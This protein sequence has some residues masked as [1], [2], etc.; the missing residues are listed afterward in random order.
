MT[1]PCERACLGHC[2]QR[3]A[4][5]TG[6]LRH[7]IRK[8][9]TPPGAHSDGCFVP[10]LSVRQPQGSQKPGGVENRRSGFSLPVAMWP[11][12]RIAASVR[13]GMAL[14]PVPAHRTEQARFTHPALGESVTRSPTESWRFAD[15]SRTSPNYRCRTASEYRLVAG[16]VVCAWHTATGAAAAS[17]SVHSS[18]GFA[19]WSQDRNSCPP[20]DFRLSVLTTVSS[21]SRVCA[22]SSL[23]ADRL[24][25]ALHPFLRRSRS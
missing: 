8:K 4:F 14:F 12:F 2:V 15:V 24:T 3:P 20:N 19:D 6:S 1:A 18:I 17:M 23:F 10:P 21:A 13:F 7:A 11:G 22:P 5:D 25:D 9:N 16:L